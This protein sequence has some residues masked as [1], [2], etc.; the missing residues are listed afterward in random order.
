MKILHRAGISV[1][2]PHCHCGQSGLHRDLNGHRS[3]VQCFPRLWTILPSRDSVLGNPS[4]SPHT[5]L[6]SNM[7]V[8]GNMCHSCKL[9]KTLKSDSQTD[10]LENWQLSRQQRSAFCTWVSLHMQVIQKSFALWWSHFTGKI[11]C[12]KFNSNHWIVQQEGKKAK[13][14]FALLNNTLM[15][16]RKPENNFHTCLH[17]CII[18]IT[19][20]HLG[21]ISLLIILTRIH[22]QQC[23]WCCNSMQAKISTFFPEVLQWIKN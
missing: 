20:L 3:W 8:P 21:K 2:V 15:R 13:P 14:S 18:I 23:T 4:L 6:K 12:V 22:Y 9:A 7:S 16:P 1:F 5:R 19:Y 11:V 10:W 17:Y